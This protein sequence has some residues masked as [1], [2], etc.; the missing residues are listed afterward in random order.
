MDCIFCKIVDE[1]MPSYTVYED[2]YCKAILDISPANKGHVI[3]IAKGHYENIY[4]IPKDDA[5][6]IFSTVTRI[7]RAIKE[8]F[9]CEGLN[10]LQNNGEIAGQTVSHFH[11]H[12]IPRYNND[13]VIIKT[14]HL[15][16][17][18]EEFQE[19]AINI[20]KSIEN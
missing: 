20:K 4:E 15:T 2:Q 17:E 3:I 16:L 9:K 10:I 14:K 1:Q 12:L 11:I 7:S 13:G 6:N 19:I 18:K 8:V 5:A